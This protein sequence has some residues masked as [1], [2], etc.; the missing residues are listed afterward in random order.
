MDKDV[1]LTIRGL[2]PNDPE[3]EMEF[4][5]A[6]RLVRK[7]GTANYAITYHE[8]ELTGLPGT[9]TRF[10]VEPDKVTLTRE[11]TR[12]T[13]V[14]YKVGERVSTVYGTSRNALEVGLTAR[15]IRS[16]ISDTGGELEINYTLDVQHSMSGMCQ[17]WLQ[18]REAPEP[19]FDD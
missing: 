12:N 1:I 7:E 9:T 6:G 4:V 19:F 3:N 14:V 17:V 2:Q 16:T 11:G 5:T 18:V 10:F 13:F 15:S 8:S